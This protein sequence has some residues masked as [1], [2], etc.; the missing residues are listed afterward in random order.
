MRVLTIQLKQVS[1]S[2]TEHQWGSIAWQW[3]LST[4]ETVFGHAFPASMFSLHYEPARNFYFYAEDPDAV[5]AFQT[6]AED[7]QLNW[8]DQNFDTILFEAAGNQ[9]GS[10]YEYDSQSD[11]WVIPPAKQDELDLR[12]RQTARL[13]TLS[14]AMVKEF[15]MI[16]AIWEVGQS[17]GLWAASD[18]SQELRDQAA[19]WKQTIE[20]YEAEE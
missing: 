8:V 11:T 1:I 9:F 13:Y 6:P 20:D 17:K 4:F 16:L 5:Q 19:A 15:K 3:D 10:D 14:M 7:P 2:D 18:F 12:E